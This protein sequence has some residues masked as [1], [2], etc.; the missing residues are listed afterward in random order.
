M[1]SPV[2][3]RRRWKLH[4]HGQSIV[5]NY[6]LGERLVHPLM[7]AYIWALYLPDYPTSSIEIRIGDK[8]KPDVVAFDGQPAVYEVYPQPLF[9]GEAGRT[10]KDKIHSIVKRFPDTHFAMSK[11]DTG[12]SSYVDLVSEALADV[13]RNAPFDLISFP[14]STKSCVDKDGNITITFDDINWVRL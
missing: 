12:L 5:V 4:A 9:W 10:S 3:G 6:G 1:L 14:E 2:L 11:W 7:K 8:Y 13:T